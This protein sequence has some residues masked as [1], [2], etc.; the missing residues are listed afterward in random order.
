MWRSW[1]EDDIETNSII[2]TSDT[3]SK[4]FEPEL[5]IKDQEQI[6]LVLE[7]L[8][9]NLNIVKTYFTHKI[10]LSEKYPSIDF[11]TALTVSNDIK[12]SAASS[13]TKLMESQIE[14]SFLRACRY[15]KVKGVKGTMCRS[16][17]LDILVRFAA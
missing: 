7:I 9:N 2:F 3:N 17:F 11:I 12:F 10:A 1:I 6:K 13:Q 4:N 14:I 15:N 5:I 8:E 16:Q